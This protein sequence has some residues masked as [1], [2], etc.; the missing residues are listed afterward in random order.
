MSKRRGALKGPQSHQPELQIAELF[1]RAPNLIAALQPH[2]LFLRHPAN[3]AFGRTRPDDVAGFERPHLRYVS[4]QLL[5]I[6][7]HIAGVRR[8][9]PFPVH[10][11]L[12]LQVARVSDDIRRNEIRADRA[13][14]VE[15]FADH[16][17][18][19]WGL[20]LKIA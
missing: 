4:D 20:M 18:S 3:D 7:Y 9:A 11:S 16:P 15:R 10:V 5:G 17:L 14:I 8:L 2:L 6:E 1:N 19:A 13:K 12:D